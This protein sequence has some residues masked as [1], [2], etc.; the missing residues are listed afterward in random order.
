MKSLYLV[1]ALVTG[2]ALFY[3][4]ISNSFIKM[5]PPK[6]SPSLS[7]STTILSP[8]NYLPPVYTCQGQGINP[9]LE[10]SNVPSQTK[11]LALIMDD[12]DAPIGIFTHWLIWNI[13]PKT[14]EIKENSVPAGAV[15]GSGTSGKSYYTPPCPPSGTHHYIFS[16]YALDVSLS[17][18][19]GSSRQ[20]LEQA[21]EGHI[22][23]YSQLITLYAKP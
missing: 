12:P 19:V 11:S 4:I 18:P 6:T 20:V 23:T 9:P 21:M 13:D 5:T 8:D 1:A 14:T 3:I 16:V 17:L 22:I 2:I 15:Q 10:I 7:L